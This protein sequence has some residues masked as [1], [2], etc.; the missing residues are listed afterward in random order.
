MEKE[1]HDGKLLEMEIRSS[2][3][4]YSQV[5]RELQANRKTLYNWF[6]KPE[7]S[8]DVAKRVGAVIG[9]DLV[10]KYPNQFTAE[11]PFQAN[12]SER[13]K[14]M[15]ESDLNYWRDKYYALLEKYTAIIEAK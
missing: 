1:Q 9:V 2:T 7:L 4:S 6:A 13:I 10:A 11:R 3:K 12:V 15:H 5:A 14:N 8:E